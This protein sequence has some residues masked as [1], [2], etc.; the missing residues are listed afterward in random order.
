MLGFGGIRKQ[1][2]WGEHRWWYVMPASPLISRQAQPPMQ[3]E[4]P[5]Q[6]E[7]LTVCDGQQGFLPTTLVLTRDQ[8]FHVGFEVPCCARHQHDPVALR[9]NKRVQRGVAF[10]G[11]PTSSTI[12]EIRPRCAACTQVLKAKLAEQQ[13]DALP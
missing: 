12:I 13:P 4:T 3:P 2:R 7:V 1:T 10:F 8:Q 11:L 6:D 9:F 5:A